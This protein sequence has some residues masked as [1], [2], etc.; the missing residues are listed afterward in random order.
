MITSFAAAQDWDG[1]WLYTYSHSSDSWDRENLSSYFDI[2]TNPAKWGFMRAGAAIFRY[3]GIGRLN[4]SGIIGL[5]KPSEDMLTSLAKLHHK[6]DRDMISMLHSYCAHMLR[7]EV[8]VRL[9]GRR[10]F[11]DVR[12]S[13]PPAEPR[14]SMDE[15]KG[16]Y[17][18]RGNGASVYVGHAERFEKATDRD[19]RITSP[20][21]VA[22]TV[23]ALDKVSLDQSRK[24]LITACGRCENTGMKF[25]E[26]RRTVGRDWGGPPVQI[27][28]VEGNVVLPEGQW[29]CEALG[30]DGTPR[31]EV[32]IA[33]REDRGV[34]KLSP[35]YKTMWY[36][37][38][39]SSKQ[40]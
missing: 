35:Q 4:R 37:L 7:M 39:Q 16:F 28:A 1:V 22:L 40:E 15:D 24:I 18:V 11:R 3:S 2:D 13:L 26:D 38:M 27:E 33:Y 12:S 25:S 10:Q 21:F 6:Y 9:R 5:T 14:W 23:T 36:F 19:I 29:K 32:P 20:N 8:A 31:Y 17:V 34:L 30:P